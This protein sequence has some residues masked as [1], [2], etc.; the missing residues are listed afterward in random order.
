MNAEPSELPEAVIRR[1]P[2]DFVVEELPAYPA[3]GKGEHLFITFRKRGLTTPDAVRALAR[4][5]GVDPR[6]AGWA[7]MKDRHAVTTQTVSFSLPMARD[8]A[9]AAAKIAVPGLSV[10]AAQ[11]HDNKLKPGH[12]IGNRFTLVLRGIDRARLAAAR[13]ILEEAGRVG[14]PNA[15]GPQRF[16]RDGDNPARALAWLAGKE[17]GPRDK[18]DQRML[19]SALQ[20]LLFNEVLARRVAEGT[21]STVLAGDVAKKHDSGGLF[22]VP[23]EG[24]ELDD[25]RARA[26]A[27]AISATGPMYGAKMRWPAGEPLAAERAVLDASALDD[28]LLEARKSLG[29]GTRR[30]LRLEVHEMAVTEESAGAAGTNLASQDPAGASIVVRFVLPKGGYATTV[31]GRAFRLRDA[32]LARPSA[33][34]PD[35]SD[36]APDSPP[37]S[38]PDAEEEPA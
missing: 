6:F 18:R 3:S 37:E 7:G 28:A 31:L 36:A 26:E 11:R 14:V 9:A 33:A 2:E 5:L 4:E 1:S 19:F 23:L 35:P 10:L 15:F 16:G 17:R 22:D 38:T 24:P 27:G 32:S 8:A 30:A 25:A 34:A 20:S 29:E 12:L 21:W 13:A